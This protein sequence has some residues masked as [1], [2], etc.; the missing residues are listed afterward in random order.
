MIGARKKV[1]DLKPKCNIGYHVCD[2]QQIFTTGGLGVS[3]VSV[4][5][6]GFVI[7]FLFI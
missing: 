3:S 6:T 7:N 1:F 5:G 2:I 4:V